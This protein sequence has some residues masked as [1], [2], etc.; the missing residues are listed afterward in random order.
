VGDPTDEALKQSKFGT[1]EV[2]IKK[3]NEKEK[4]KRF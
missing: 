1:M 2:P 4:E 3:K